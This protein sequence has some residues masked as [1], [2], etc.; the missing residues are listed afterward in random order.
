MPGQ[1]GV[2]AQGHGTPGP[3]H[4]ALS[5]SGDP[6]HSQAHWECGQGDF[7]LACGLKKYWLFS[8]CFLL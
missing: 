5:P 4:R 7:A 1:P 6:G 8:F 2:G 3:G